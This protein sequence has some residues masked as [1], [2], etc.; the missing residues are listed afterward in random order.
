MYPIAAHPNSANAALTATRSE[1]LRVPHIVVACF[2]LDVALALLHTAVEFAIRAGV[3]SETD[4]FHLGREENIP[5]WYSSTKLGV[6]GLVFLCTAFLIAKA[7]KLDR[8]AVLLGAAMFIVLSVDETALL[9]ERIGDLVNTDSIHSRFIESGIWPILC[10]PVFV[11]GIV[12][13]YRLGRRLLKR[14][15]TA[16]LASGLAILLAGAVGLEMA[17]NL[18]TP[19]SLAYHGLVVCEETLEM[20][21]ETVLLWGAIRFAQ[22]HGIGLHADS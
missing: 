20:I 9:H 17:A 11:I 12:V 6:V 14:N 16:I 15:V 3:L 10:A 1:A 2:I 8:L 5:T 18:V 19:Y 22:S 7:S 13:V 21:G 4:L